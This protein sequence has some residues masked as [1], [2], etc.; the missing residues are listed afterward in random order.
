MN[1]RK[2]FWLLFLVFSESKPSLV[3]H[4]IVQIV[5]NFHLKN[6][7][8]VEVFYNSDRLTILDETLN[9]LSKVKE[10]KVTKVDTSNE[11]TLHTDKNTEIKAVFKT[12]NYVNVDNKC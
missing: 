5:R 2:I 12:E 8:K 10:V 3:P 11:A 1:T 9:I 6:S 4:A 7:L